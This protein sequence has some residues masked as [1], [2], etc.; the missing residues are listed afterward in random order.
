MKFPKEVLAQ[1]L[2]EHYMAGATNMDKPPYNEPEEPYYII[3]GNALHAAFRNGVNGRPLDGDRLLEFL[4]NVPYDIS[5]TE[6]T[7]IGQLINQAGTVFN[8]KWSVEDKMVFIK[9]L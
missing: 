3:V 6:D 5:T 1:M 8:A 9:P 4:V 7:I 2:H